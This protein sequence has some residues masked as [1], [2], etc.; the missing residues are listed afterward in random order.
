MPTFILRNAAGKQI[1]SSTF[2]VFM[3]VGSKFAKKTSAAMLRI[4][5][6]DDLKKRTETVEVQG[7]TK[8]PFVL[9][10]NEIFPLKSSL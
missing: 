2:R 8:L 4:I 1:F 7:V 10:K 5:L 6:K 3:P 9:T